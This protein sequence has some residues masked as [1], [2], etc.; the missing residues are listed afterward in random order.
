V[1]DW[2]EQP[3]RSLRVHV[4]DRIITDKG[5]KIVCE[6]RRRFDN[7][8]LKSS[9]QLV[10]A[11]VNHYGGKIQYS[12]W[13]ERMLIGKSGDISSDEEKNFASMT[14]QLSGY[15]AGHDKSISL[16][17]IAKKF[18]TLLPPSS[19]P[20]LSPSPTSPLPP[21]LVL[22]DPVE[23]STVNTTKEMEEEKNGTESHSSVSSM[24][25]DSKSGNKNGTIGKKR[26]T[27][28]NQKTIPAPLSSIL[29]SST[30]SIAADTPNN[31]EQVMPSTSKGKKRRTKNKNKWRLAKKRKP[32]TPSTGSVGALASSNKRNKDTS[33]TTATAAVDDSDNTSTA[34]DDDTDT[35]TDTPTRMIATGDI[36][37]NV[38]GVIDLGAKWPTRRISPLRHID[39]DVAVKKDSDLIPVT[40]VSFMKTA[41]DSIMQQHHEQQG[42]GVVDDSTVNH[43]LMLDDT[44][45]ESKVSQSS[46]NDITNDEMLNSKDKYE[47]SK[48]VYALEK[49]F[50]SRWT[51][52]HYTRNHVYQVLKQIK[53]R[54]NDYHQICRQAGIS[55]Q[56][57]GRWMAMPKL[58]LTESYMTDNEWRQRQAKVCISIL[59]RLL[60]KF[61]VTS[62]D[63]IINTEQ[64]KK[65][66]RAKEP[67][68]HQCQK[69][70]SNGVPLQTC[71]NT[72]SN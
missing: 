69:V 50:E 25:T 21:S 63:E 23:T 8:R 47:F 61:N 12:S 45:V 14:L 56:T 41:S 32:S 60:T 49:V 54:P 58:P 34:N 62:F 38:V 26:K 57:V 16:T 70:G 65:Q 20:T 53:E 10:V 17:E 68:C 4:G 52:R 59:E 37:T 42:Q 11:K 18:Q 64:R 28:K 35:D 22:N 51:N 1:Y 31:G 5:E 13:S 39:D 3:S 9:I 15:A 30:T 72:K 43:S 33:T 55:Y 27:K 19:T 2:I 40:P 29:S 46:L 44:V 67:L 6:L 7:G 66:A 71:H 24:S 48:G 36:I